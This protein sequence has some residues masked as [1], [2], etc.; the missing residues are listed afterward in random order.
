MCEPHCNSD[1]QVLVSLFEV[2][3]L[4][5]SMD[6]KTIGYGVQLMF[7]LLVN[8]AP[9]VSLYES[10]RLIVRSPS[11]CIYLRGGRGAR[12][13]VCMSVHLWG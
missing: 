11:P 6:A 2:V 1:C 13:R 4:L 7:Y 10:R 3:Y 8:I 5:S 12:N 9:R